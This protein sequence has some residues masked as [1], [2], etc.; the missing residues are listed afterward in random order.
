[1]THQYKISGMSCQH[2]AANVQKALASHP[3]VE[4]AEV[5]LN[6]ATAV[7]KMKHH[8]PTEQLQELVSKFG[9]YKIDPQ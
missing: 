8:V 1:M 6:S 5:A 2:C 4:K 3:E 7:V 9:A